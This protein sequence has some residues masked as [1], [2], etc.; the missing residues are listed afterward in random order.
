[1]GI[2]G[3]GWDFFVWNLKKLPERAAKY[4]ADNDVSPGRAKI[5]ELHNSNFGMF[6]WNISSTFEL[7]YF[8]ANR[9]GVNRGDLIVEVQNKF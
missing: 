1:M 7:W 8:S 3:N 9:Y 2:H 4:T 6:V 5:F